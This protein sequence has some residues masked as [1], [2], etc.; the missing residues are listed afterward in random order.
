MGHVADEI[1]TAGVD[2]TTSTEPRRAGV[3]YLL[4][5]EPLENQV[6]KPDAIDDADAVFRNPPTLAEL[7]ADLE[8]L[9]SDESFDIPDMTD[10]EWAEFVAALHE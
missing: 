2:S 5:D 4:G 8:P 9:R 6:P 1:T 10:E 7:V 3:D